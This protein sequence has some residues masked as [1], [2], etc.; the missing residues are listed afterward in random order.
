MDK[1][2]QR[3]DGGAWEGKKNK[4]RCVVIGCPNLSTFLKNAFSDRA[5]NFYL[6]TGLST[7]NCLVVKLAQFVHMFA[8]ASVGI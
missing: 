5:C 6:A 2:R 8:L 4:R 7:P 1:E 3:A